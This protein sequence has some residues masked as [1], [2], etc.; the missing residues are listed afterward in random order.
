M[1][2]GLT[3]SHFLGKLFGVPF[4][5]AFMIVFI[6]EIFQNSNPQNYWILYKKRRKAKK[7][8]TFQ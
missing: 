1:F 3:L 8:E 5:K 7:L 6:P 4:E 2:F